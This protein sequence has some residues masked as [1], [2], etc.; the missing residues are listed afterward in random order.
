ML[1][2]NTECLSNLR[3]PTFGFNGITRSKKKG[4]EKEQE[5]IICISANLSSQTLA[6]KMNPVKHRR[7]GNSSPHLS[8]NAATGCHPAFTRARWREFYTHLL[9]NED[10]T[11]EGADKAVTGCVA[12][13]SARPIFL[14][15]KEQIHTDRNVESTP[16]V[17]CDTQL[18]SASPPSTPHTHHRAF[19]LTGLP[20]A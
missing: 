7:A 13:E 16:V 8:F 19:P 15:T 5:M 3:L 10:D 14:S 1:S 12:D 6:D 17:R 20:A 9:L 11:A 18:N 4:E 2:Y